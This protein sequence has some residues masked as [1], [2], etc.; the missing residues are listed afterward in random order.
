MP[1]APHPLPRPTAD[2]PLETAR[3]AL[4]ASLPAP[5]AEV[6][7]VALREALGRVLAQDQASP[8]DVPA[9][10]CAAMDG[11]AL[12]AAERGLAAGPG[13]RL[14]GAGLAGRPHAGPVPAGACVRITTGALLPDGLDTVLPLEQARA[15]EGRVWAEGEGVA[16]GAHVRR[17]GEDLARGQRVLPA[18]RLLGAAELG[19]AASMGLAHLPVRRRLRVAFLATGDELCPPGQPLPRGG[20][21]D[22]NRV[23]LEAMLHR[24]GGVAPLDF[25]TVR[26]DPAAL[27]A[28]FREAAAAAD[29]VIS[30]G[31]VSVGEADH[32]KAVM[33]RLG[34]VDFWQ[35]ALRPGR[36]MAVGRLPAGPGGR[37]ALLVGLPGNPVAVMVTFHAVVRGLLLAL[38]GA[39]P[40]R[41]PTV[42]A[43]CAAPIAKRPGRS[44]FP[45]GRLERDADGRWTVSLAGG[46]GAAMLRGMAEGDGLILLEHGRGPVAAGEEVEVLPFH[47]L[48]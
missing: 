37:E 34:R 47:A 14:A 18:G 11:Y 17:A 4:L 25:G 6:E 43:R 2:L 39:T 40:P 24:L 30:T 31:G 32:T 19:L 21:Y 35:L 29:V 26:D 48:A 3:A 33:A 16:A 7:T 41:L 36:P 44:E 10:D 27:E 8:I 42:H 28:R 1:D 45:R 22:S 12:R 13:L 15:A 5:V 9:G 46:Q 20:V 38:A 23:V